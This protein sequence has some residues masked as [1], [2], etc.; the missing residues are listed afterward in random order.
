MGD[1]A[2]AFGQDHSKFIISFAQTALDFGPAALVDQPNPRCGLIM[3]VPTLTLQWHI[4]TAT[5]VP[6]Y[7]SSVIGT[8]AVDGWAVTFGTAPSPLMAVPNVIPH[9]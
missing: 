4:K 8:L 9:P 2:V 1:V 5:N 7:S 3:K 6:L